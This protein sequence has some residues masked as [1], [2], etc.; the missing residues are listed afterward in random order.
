MCTTVLHV[1]TG[2][3]SRL[4]VQALLCKSALDTSKRGSK[5]SGKDPLSK[6]T[7]PLG[8]ITINFTDR[9]T[10]KDGSLPVIIHPFSC[11]ITWAAGTPL[12]LNFPFPKPFCYKRLRSYMWFHQPSVAREI[13]KKSQKKEIG[14]HNHPLS[15]RKMK[16]KRVSQLLMVLFGKE[17]SKVYS[18]NIN[19]TGL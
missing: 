3:A 10:C 4:C 16:G 5:W 9:S 8:N 6:C 14:K 17:D 18:Y 11:C 1:S 19:I 15:W 13:L 2:A 12:I 7:C